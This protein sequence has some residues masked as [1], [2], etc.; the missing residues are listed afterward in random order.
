MPATWQLPPTAVTARMASRGASLLRRSLPIFNVRVSAKR[1]PDREK[2]NA[3][4][5]SAAHRHADPGRRYRHAPQLYATAFLDD[6]ASL[7]FVT[8]FWARGNDRII[9]LNIIEQFSAWNHIIRMR[10]KSHA[11]YSTHKCTSLYFQVSSL[12]RFYL[13]VS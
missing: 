6:V 5:L 9:F 7:S 3:R 4:L 12:F 11:R 2:R 1:I 8:H 13:T 10:E